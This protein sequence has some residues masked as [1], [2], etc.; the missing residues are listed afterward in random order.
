MY[1]HKYGIKYAEFY[2]EW[3]MLYEKKNQIED[4]LR[5]C[6][7][8]FK[9]VSNQEKLN[10]LYKRL[11]PSNMAN[12]AEATE[13]FGFDCKR[14]YPKYPNFGEEVSFE[15]LRANTYYKLNEQI[16]QRVKLKIEEETRAYINQIEELKKQ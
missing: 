9:A 13:K 11:K 12:V 2:V 15:E 16:E 5:I 10:Q 3:A 6:E 8:G 14:L 1:K 7:Y 4:A